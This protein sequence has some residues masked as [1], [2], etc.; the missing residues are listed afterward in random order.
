MS[1]ETLKATQRRKNTWLYNKVFSGE[2][3]D[4]GCGA[5]VLNLGN[6]FPHVR[7]VQPFDV[8]HGDAQ[9]ITQYVHR[10]F[11]FVHSSQCL[12][13]MWDVEEALSNWWALVRPGG[14]LIVS[15]PDEDLYE[16][17]AFPSRFNPDHKWTF[18]IYKKVT[19]SPRHYNVL[20]L[21]L[22]LQDFEILKLELVDTNYNYSLRGMDQTLGNAEAFIEFI[23]RKQSS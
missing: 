18:S 20:Q 19:W 14:F 23:L 7:S 5:D 1:N 6:E 11:D 8:I 21:I 22:G 3:I 16:Q 13:H 4:I 15:V 2:G 10:Q 17:G 12:E 9:K